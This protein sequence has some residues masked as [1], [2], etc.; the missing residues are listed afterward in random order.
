MSSFQQEPLSAW[1]QYFLE[2]EHQG[3]VFLTQPYLER[4]GSIFLQLDSSRQG[5]LVEGMFVDA[6]PAIHARKQHIW[7]TLRSF[8]DFD[9]NGRIERHEFV[10][11]FLLKALRS[12]SDPSSLN[13]SKMGDIVLAA[14]VLFNGH[15]ETAISEMESF[16]LGN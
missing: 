10:G 9:G 16:L 11:Y 14:H 6:L 7:N 4:I 1:E 8:I 12:L 15:L 5:V 2:K 13:T 3:G